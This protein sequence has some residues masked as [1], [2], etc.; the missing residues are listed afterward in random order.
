MALAESRDERVAVANLRGDVLKTQAALAVARADNSTVLS[1]RVELA[2]AM[3]A[4]DSLTDNASESD[5]VD[6]NQAG[7]VTASHVPPRD[8]AIAMVDVPTP[9][10]AGECPSAGFRL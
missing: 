7:S 3:I 2:E 8:L 1:L 5:S 9:A 10:E 6:A 4:L